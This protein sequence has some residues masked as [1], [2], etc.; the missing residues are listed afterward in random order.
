[1]KFPYVLMVH[2]KRFDYSS[3]LTERVKL[4]HKVSFPLVIS[5][6]R[7]LHK[8]NTRASENEQNG[9]ESDGKEETP[10]SS[11]SLEAFEL[12][13]KIHK[14]QN[15]IAAYT[16][17]LD[18]TDEV[19]PTTDMWRKERKEAKMQLDQ[20][21]EEWKKINPDKEF[22][23]PTAEQPLTKDEYKEGNNT[24][25]SFELISFQEIMNCTLY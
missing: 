7:Y 11:S 3:L 13:R 20:L 19:S 24:L 6:D 10:S 2:L 23:S 5:L 25:L 22:P 18:Q 16:K 9:K 4:S 14:L 8:N 21:Q 17:L 12:E 1:V 15:S